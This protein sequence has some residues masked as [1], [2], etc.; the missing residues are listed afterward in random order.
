MINKKERKI[1]ILIELICFMTVTLVGYNVTHANETLKTFED[2][3]QLEDISLDNCIDFAV[4][5]EQIKQIE[6]SVAENEER[7]RKEAI[8]AAKLRYV[9]FNPYNIEEKSNVSMATLCTILKDTEFL[10]LADVLVAC[11][12]YYNIN[13][14]ALLGLITLESAHGKSSRAIYSNNISGYAVYNDN[15]R[16]EY[17]ESWTECLQETARLLREQY[18]NQNGKYYVGS[19]IWNVNV[20]Y[21]TSEHWADEIISIVNDYSNKLK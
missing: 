10:P 11:E 18:L 9:Y 19:S 5:D 14:F 7:A 13:L 16:G 15:S 17:F 20:H 8:E 6:Q 4:T 1:L 12:D 3:I 2:E 21:S